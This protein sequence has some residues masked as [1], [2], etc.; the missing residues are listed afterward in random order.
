MKLVPQIRTQIEPY[1]SKG[2]NC[3]DAAIHHRLSN[4]C[5]FNKII[6]LGYFVD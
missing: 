1:N 2:T 6:S 5:T 4:K 3:Q